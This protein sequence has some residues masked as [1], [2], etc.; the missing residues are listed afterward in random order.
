MSQFRLSTRAWKWLICSLTA[1]FIVL[2]VFDARPALRAIVLEQRHGTLGATLNDHL[3]D[4]PAN[5]GSYALRI[6]AL[7]AASPLL[8]QG[9]R[10]GDTL[11]YDRPEDRYRR[12]AVGEAVG[13]TLNV[14]GQPRHL[15]VAAVATAVPAA[16]AFDYLGRLVLTLVAMLFCVLVSFKQDARPGLHYLALVFFALSLLLFMTIN[17]APA[18]PAFR[19]IKLLQLGS[20]PLLWYWT[21]SFALQYQAYASTP[22][23]RRLERA[24]PWYLALT[25]VS[26][27][28][29]LW[30]GLG[31]DVAALMPATGAA[32]AGGL[33]ITIASLIEGWRQS[34]GEVR[35]R[36]RWMLLSFALGSI[37]AVVAWVPAFDAAIG[38]VRYTIVAMFAGQMAMYVGLAYAVLRHRIFNFEFAV[39]RMVVFSVVSVLLLCT[40]GVVERL[41][42]GLLHGGGH[43]DAPALTLV[44][45]GAIALGVYLVFHHLHTRVERWVERI[46]FHQ[47]HDNENKLRAY[48]RRAAHITSAD[49]LLAS[50]S[51]AIDRFTAQAGCALYLRQD[52][53]SYLL[54]ACSTLQGAPAILAPDTAIAVAL[55]SD[56]VAQDAD[57]ADLPGEL[58]LPM[59]HRG[60]LHGFVLVGAK[61][62][63]ER[64]RPDERDALDF[65]T[66]DLQA[67]RADALEQQVRALTLHNEQQG[68]ELLLMAGRR[69]GPRPLLA[70]VDA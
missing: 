25:L 64:Y 46:F 10:V 52:D 8:A 14:A 4:H 26:S 57:S 41:S 9:A 65:A 37:P 48:V 3:A 42:S 70:V 58:A 29:A 62:S 16:E 55:R 32:L 54:S 20:Y 43:A 2:L 31:H 13:L 63:G 6:L 5:H 17:Y 33:T 12:F 15:V 11:R 59:S 19:A 44:I 68:S 27:G 45:D 22:L 39:S 24:M 28:F 36:H 67:L 38:G 1:L 34:T 69:K 61:R 49:N 51:S 18:G 66:L 30:F 50:Y 40:F 53:N 56:M 47:W 21:A 23:R 7:D 60:A 35:D